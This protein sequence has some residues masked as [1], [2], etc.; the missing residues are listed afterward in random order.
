MCVV[1]IKITLNTIVDAW[2][3]NT[4]MHVGFNVRVR[5]RVHTSMWSWCKHILC[6]HYNPLASF[7]AITHNTNWQKVG[8]GGGGSEQVSYTTLIWAT[9]SCSWS[10]VMMH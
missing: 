5:V 1:L 4:D 8:G 9:H 6:A 10:I 7:V 3:Y 2:K